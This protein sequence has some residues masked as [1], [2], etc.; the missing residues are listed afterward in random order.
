MFCFV[1]FY[2]AK[3]FGVCHCEVPCPKSEAQP[4]G[5]ATLPSMGPSH[6]GASVDAVQFSVTDL[7]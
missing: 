7:S 6:W 1:L 2:F 4:S 3:E 5:R